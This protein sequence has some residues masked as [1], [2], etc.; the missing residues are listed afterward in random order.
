M[1]AEDIQGLAREACEECIQ[2]LREPEKSQAKPAIKVLCA[3]ISA[4]RSSVLVFAMKCSTLKCLLASISQYTICQAVPHLVRLFLSPNEAL[5]RAPI[6]V[7]LAELITAA[8]DS[9]AK[10]L[11]STE[12]HVSLMP[13]K[14]DVLGVFTVGLKTTS[15]CQPA[16]AGLN[17]MVTTPAL[18]ADEELGFIVHNVN[19]ILQA[20]PDD[21]DGDNARFV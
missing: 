13:F 3:F 11:T 5:N 21:E 19:S 18:L 15:C 14:D 17:A 20:D 16:L 4:T 12:L 6:T 1:D 2:I 8:R 9:M 10:S 7:L